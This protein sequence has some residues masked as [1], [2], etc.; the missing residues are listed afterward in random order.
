MTLAVNPVQAREILALNLRANLVTMV[1][2]SPGTAKSSIIKSLAKEYNMKLIDIRLAQCDPT[3]LLGFP[4]IDEASGRAKYV[5]MSHFPLEG[6]ELPRDENGKPMNGWLIFLD[7]FNSG[8]KG[9]QKA[10]YKL[11]LERMIGEHNLHP[12]ARM[13]AAGNLDTDG[14]IVEE[15]STALQSRICHL[16]MLPDNKAWLQWARTEGDIDFRIIS[17]IEFKPDCL[18]TFDPEKADAQETYACYRTWEFA[19]QQLQQ[20]P[21][22]DQE[23]NLVAI[24]SSSLSEGVGRSFSSFLRNMSKMPKFA[25]IISNPEKAAVPQE[26]GIQYALTGS[27]GENADSSNID[28]VM[29]YVA[30]LPME[31]Q[32]ITLREILRRTETMLQETPIQ[33]WVKVNG[34]EFQKI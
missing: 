6:D 12:R 8:D 11:V 16:N 15:M 34:R 26:P 10:S 2:G 9:V 17:F 29:K 23:K 28:A 18:Y 25:Q 19:N 14:A 21:D 3:D 27:I 30:R 31:F 24:F 1:K 13:I 5:P 4:F 32:I 33:D 20:I 22:I 7:E